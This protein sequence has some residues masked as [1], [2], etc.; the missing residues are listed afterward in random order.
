[1]KYVKLFLI[2]LLIAGGVY[3]ALNWGGIFGGDTQDES[4]VS[5]DDI[6]LDKECGIIRKDWREKGCWDES[7]YDVHSKRIQR[8]KEQKRLS[9]SGFQ[10]LGSTLQTE[11]AAAACKAYQAALDAGAKCVHN[12]VLDAYKGVERLAELEALESDSRIQDVKKKHDYYTTVYKFVHN[13]H[14][15]TPTL[16]KEAKWKSF[17]TLK[18]SILNRAKNLRS[19]EKSGHKVLFEEMKSIPDFDDGLNVDLLTP[20]LNKKK[21]AFYDKLYGLIVAHF[22]SLDPKNPALLSYVYS[23]F[24]DEVDQ[25]PYLGSKGERLISN[26]LDYYEQYKETA[27]LEEEARKAAEKAVTE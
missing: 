5:S 19:D 16:D 14:P 11:A 18:E 17:K 24:A 4:F 10:T 7:L 8:W 13:S 2:F 21:E 22:N 3:V 26:L 15:I 25:S 27:R 6:D 9:R 20:I 23:A 1:M 12:N